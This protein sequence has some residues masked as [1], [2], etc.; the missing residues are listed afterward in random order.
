[1]YVG[2]CVLQAATRPQGP[3]P[4]LSVPLDRSLSQVAQPPAVHVSTQR[5]LAAQSAIK[6]RSNRYYYHCYYL[7]LY[8][9]LF[10]KLSQ[11]RILSLVLLVRA[12]L[13]LQ[14]GPHLLRPSSILYLLRHH[15]WVMFS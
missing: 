9:L 13:G 4:A 3:I 11:T 6:V 12:A 15:H 8:F 14:M 2:T 10:L 5:T 7:P 1:M